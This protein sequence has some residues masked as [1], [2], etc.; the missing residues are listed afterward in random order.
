MIVFKET[1]IIQTT[2]ADLKSQGYVCQNNN[3]VIESYKAPGKKDIHYD[4]DKQVF[5]M[6]GISKTKEEPFK[7]IVAGGRKFS[8]YELLESKLDKILSNKTNVEIVSGKANG[9]DSLGEKYAKKRG[10]KVK[11][12]PANWDDYGNSAGPRRN[13]EM[14]DYADGLVAFWDGMSKGTAHMIKVAREKGLKVSVI[15]Y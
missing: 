8:N 13:I 7:V 10:F 3:T 11:E 12:F 6:N 1:N 5:F 2:L 9:A 15:H 14:A 4:N